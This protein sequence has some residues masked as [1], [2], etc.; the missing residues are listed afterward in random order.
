MMLYLCL[1]IEKPIIAFLKF[2]SP[3][4][5]NDILVTEQQFLKW[6][7][8]VKWNIRID[9]AV[10]GLYVE[11]HSEQLYPDP[12]HSWFSS[13][14]PLTY[15][16]T[17]NT[18]GQQTTDATSEMESVPDNL[19]VCWYLYKLQYAKCVKHES[20]CLGPALVLGIVLLKQRSVQII[21]SHVLPSGNL[22]PPLPHSRKSYSIDS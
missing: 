22:N 14:V 12:F 15:V 1:H 4:N 8:Q 18:L 2:G 9:M 13:H 20:R 17:K 10:G 11:Q 6:R 5:D 3:S 21:P 16:G 19:N 7:T